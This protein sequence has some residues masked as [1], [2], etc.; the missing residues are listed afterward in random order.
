MKQAPEVV[1][2][3]ANHLTDTDDSLMNEPHLNI[4][5]FCA[6]I[7]QINPDIWSF[8]SNEETFDGPIC[9]KRKSNSSRVKDST[10]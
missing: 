3:V 4:I 5:T 9:M 10:M 2:K 1:D 7:T 6:Q 8:K